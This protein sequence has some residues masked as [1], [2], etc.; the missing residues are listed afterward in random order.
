MNRIII[1]HFLFLK[2]FKYIW[3]YITSTCEIERMSAADYNFESQQTCSNN[4]SPLRPFQCFEINVWRWNHYESRPI[5]T[6]SSACETLIISLRIMV[7]KFFPFLGASSHVFILYAY[8]RHYYCTK[9]LLC[10]RV[11]HLIL[12]KLRLS[13]EMNFLP[14]SFVTSV[15]IS[16]WRWCSFFKYSESLG[17]Y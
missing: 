4:A 8:T 3:T 6:R 17:R 16:F 14:C 9:F 15:F 12:V 10:V 7:S 13:P 11:S 1:Y 2:T 5:H